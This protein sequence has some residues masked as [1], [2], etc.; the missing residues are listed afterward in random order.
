VVEQPT[1]ERRPQIEALRLRLA[2]GRA[3]EGVG[4]QADAIEV[5]KSLPDE[6]EALDAKRL[7]VQ[8]D[9]EL[10]RS[11][12]ATGGLENYQKAGALSERAASLAEAAHLDQ[13]APLAAVQVALDGALVGRPASE[14]DAALERARSAVRRVGPGGPAEYHLERVEASVANLRGQ[15][16]ASAVH[17]R[18]AL[19]M[20]D[21]LYGRDSDESVRAANNLASE[22]EP[23]GA[24]DE[25]IAL[26]RRAITSSEA[27]LGP[28][29]TRALIP[30]GNLSELLFDLGRTDECQQVL[31]GLFAGLGPEDR[32][33]VAFSL[34]VRAALQAS[35]G[36]HADSLQTIAR[37][38]EMG[39]RLHM[40]GTPGSTDLFRYS[41]EAYLRDGQPKLAAAAYDSYLAG[42]SA[43]G[44]SD[45]QVAFL[46]LGGW[47]HLDAGEPKVAL[48]LLERA[49]KLSGAHPFYPGWVPRLRYQ[50]AKALVLTHGDRKRAE[51]LAQAA[52][53][54]L[55]GVAVAKDLLKEVDAWRA[56]AFK[57]VASK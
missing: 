6:A 49:L 30:M 19:E 38:I 46:R 50:I 23:L 25:E 26:Y 3:L 14:V 53:D 37:A 13:L 31:D 21:R 29:N 5:L 41:I 7:E 55:Q 10:A 48:P 51:A 24:Y 32:R 18:R 54:E 9:L 20:S 35:L 22:L 11:Y 28:G 52:H 15:D 27:L 36:K 56:T 12:N 2:Q 8:A 42:P 4:R 57:P 40:P 1:P 16:A 17:A 34:A 45:S 33:E 47:A 43:E 39:T 44:D